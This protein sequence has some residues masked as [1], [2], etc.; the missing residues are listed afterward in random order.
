MNEMIGKVLPILLLMML[1]I[2]IRQ[3]NVISPEGAKGI[4]TIVVNVSLSSVLLL[5]FMEIQL[6]IQHLYIF[7]LSMVLFAVMMLVG[8]LF[9]LIPAT[10]HRYNMFMSTACAFSLV[11]LALFIIIYGEENIAIFSVIGLA[12][13]IFVWV[14]YYSLLRVKIGNKKFSGGELAKV[15]TTPTLICIGIGLL[16]NITGIHT[17]LSENAIWLGFVGSVDMVSNT[18]TPLILVLLG[19]G[20][21]IN[22]DYLKQSIKL[23]VVRFAVTAAIGLPFVLFVIKPLLPPDP[24]VEISFISLLLI[25]PMFSLPLLVGNLGDEEGEEITSNAIAISTVICVTAFVAYGFIN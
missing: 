15:F 23:L 22:K 13:E 17:A 9:N 16:L 3:K 4:R 25:P 2:F 12:H 20:L 7:G 14:I 18:A 6:D 24:F 21:T 11:G 1:G 19:Y 10:K 5:M 8:N